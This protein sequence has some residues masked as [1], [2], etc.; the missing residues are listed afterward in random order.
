MGP[1]PTPDPDTMAAS[2]EA[3]SSERMSSA[4]PPPPPPPPLP[5]RKGVFTFSRRKPGASN[6]TDSDSPNASTAAGAADAGEGTGGAAAVSPVVS[7]VGSDTSSR[8][9]R[10]AHALVTPYK[11]ATMEVFTCVVWVR[12]GVVRGKTKVDQQTLRHLFFC[13]FCLALSLPFTHK[14]E[15]ALP[16]SLLVRSIVETTL[17]ANSPSLSLSHSLSYTPHSLSH[18]ICILS[19]CSVCHQ[20]H[21]VPYRGVLLLVGATA[22][23]CVFPFQ[24]LKVG[25]RP[26]PTLSSARTLACHTPNLLQAEI[27]Y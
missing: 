3:R 2:A 12:L 9:A 21:G 6:G 1:N 19:R 10:G 5:S 27:T 18:T 16:H 26:H 17:S 22:C 7:P 13:F 23:A 20:K 15:P 4:I 8:S 11:P 25:Q 24:G 14:V